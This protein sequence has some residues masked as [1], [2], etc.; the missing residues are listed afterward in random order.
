MLATILKSGSNYFSD[1]VLR[2]TIKDRRTSNSLPKLPNSSSLDDVASHQFILV[3][4]SEFN[5]I[6]SEIGRL[7]DMLVHLEQART[8]NRRE[9]ETNSILR[10]DNEILREGLDITLNKIPGKK[11]L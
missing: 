4:K 11:L 3:A 6:E 1:S 2:Q 7:T 10:R 5:A 9:L 8:E